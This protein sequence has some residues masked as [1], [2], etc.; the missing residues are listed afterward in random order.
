MKSQLP[1]PSNN[2][3]KWLCL[4]TILYDCKSG[5]ET[6]CIITK[7]LTVQTSKCN[8]VG[9]SCSPQMSQ[10]WQTNWSRKFAVFS[11]QCC[12]V[13]CSVLQCSVL[14]FIN[15]VLTEKRNLHSEITSSWVHH[16]AVTVAMAS[17][18]LLQLHSRWHVDLHLITLD[19]GER[20]NFGKRNSEEYRM[21]FWNN[22]WYKCSNGVPPELLLVQM[23]KLR[24]TVTLI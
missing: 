13:Q 23:K 10:M 14:L 16:T 17:K 20:I 11:V 2:L 7:G 1:Y 15:S 9:C 22:S 3:L 8:W 18:L 24:N 21:Y 12:S 19:V 5:G 4:Y 6:C